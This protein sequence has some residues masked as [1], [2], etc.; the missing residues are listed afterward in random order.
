MKTWR[1]PI[2]P[3]IFLQ[4]LD[5]YVMG[6][7]TKNRQIH[8]AA[9]FHYVLFFVAKNLTPATPT[10]LWERNV[11]HHEVTLNSSKA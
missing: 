1:K 7:V 5:M 6:K 10:Y 3:Y 8:S 11:W 9:N 2:E 4:A